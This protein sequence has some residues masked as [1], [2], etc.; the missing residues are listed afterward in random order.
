MVD[1]VRVIIGKKAAEHARMA[2]RRGHCEDVG[3]MS[4][5]QIQV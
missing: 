4:G 2:Q 3:V 1:I 5:R